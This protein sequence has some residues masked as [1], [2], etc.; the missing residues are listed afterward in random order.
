MLQECEIWSLSVHKRKPVLSKYTTGN[1]IIYDRSRTTQRTI[2]PRRM[3]MQGH[4]R[5]NL[6]LNEKFW[7]GKSEGKR[8]LGRYRHR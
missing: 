4:L 2:K 1:L 8:A 5:E 6:E 3:R 7:S